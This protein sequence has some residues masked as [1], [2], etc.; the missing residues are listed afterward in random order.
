[1]FASCQGGMLTLIRHVIY[2]RGDE[3]E[4]DDEDVILLIIVF[5][6]ILPCL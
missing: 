2:E 4:D 1:M 3:D 5:F 6:N